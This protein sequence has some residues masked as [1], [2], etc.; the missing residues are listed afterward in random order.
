MIIQFQCIRFPKKKKKKK[1]SGPFA[2]RRGA[3]WREWLNI[4]R[5]TA[6]IALGKIYLFSIKTALSLNQKAVKDNQWADNRPLWKPVHLI[7]FCFTLSKQRNY[8][9]TYRLNLCIRLDQY[10]LR[11][12]WQNSVCISNPW[13]IP[14]LHQIVVKR[15]RTIFHA[16]SVDSG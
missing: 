13:I 4:I 16:L 8:L 3:V 7:V 10:P 2:V 9:G 1:G 12:L 6:C 14:P 5:R 11:T 15:L